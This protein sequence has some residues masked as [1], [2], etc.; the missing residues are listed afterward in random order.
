M[1]TRE[2]HT[3]STKREK[4][5][6]NNTIIKHKNVVY[7]K[8]MSRNKMNLF[9][10]TETNIKM[11][12]KTSRWQLAVLADEGIASYSIVNCRLLFANKR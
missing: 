10:G 4:S 2:T 8:S 9:V 12:R 1:S 5:G 11:T 6:N 7:K 3:A